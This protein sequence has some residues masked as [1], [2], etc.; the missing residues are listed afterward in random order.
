MFAQPAGGPDRGRRTGRER[1][2][3]HRDAPGRKPFEQPAYQGE[4][5]DG[6]QP[7]QY[8]DAADQVELPP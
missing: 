6:R 8:V 1:D 5:L 2:V 3:K 4:S 7:L